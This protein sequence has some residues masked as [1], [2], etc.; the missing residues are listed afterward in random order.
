MKGDQKLRCGGTSYLCARINGLEYQV[1]DWCDPQ[2]AEQC[3]ESEKGHIDILVGTEK[4]ND[5]CIKNCNSYNRVGKYANNW[6][7]I[8]CSKPVFPTAFKKA[9]GTGD[10][11]EY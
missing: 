3:T 1:I 2:G 5:E 4:N 9:Q 11:S 7:L 6:E 8:V 10:G